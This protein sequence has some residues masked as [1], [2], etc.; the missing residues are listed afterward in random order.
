M[1]LQ[2]S[3]REMSAKTRRQGR[4]SALA[5]QFVAILLIG[6]MAMPT[7][8]P[9]QTLA[10]DSGNE[11]FRV[12]LKSREFVPVPGV[13]PAMKRQQQAA[14]LG[15]RIHVLVQ[16]WQIPSGA[17]RATLENAA[18]ELLAYV[19]ANTW[20]ASMPA[21]L[22]LQSDA[23]AGVRWIGA[24][25]P[26][27]RMAPTLRAGVIGPHATHDDGT[28]SLDV[29]FLADVTNVEVTRL[30]ARYNGEIEAK[31]TDFHR[32][33]VRLDPRAIS[34]LAGEDGV[35]WIAE[36]A[37][38][39]TT[40]NDGARARTNADA[41]QSAPYNL[42]GSGVDLGIW[43]GGR[44]D[45][46]VDFSGRLTVVDAGASVSDHAT[47]VAGTMAGDGSNSAS[48][49][50]SPLQW[51]GMAPGADIISYYWD[52]NLIDHNG[53]INTYGIELSQNSWGYT[54]KQ[55]WPYQNCYLYGN[56]DYDAPDYDDIITGRYGK[57]I[58]V[59]FSAGNERN[60]GDCG[61]SGTPPY[62]N[63]ANIGPPATAKNIIAV[64]A[65]NSNDDSMTS[66]SSWGPMDDGRI[67][68]D[69]VAPGCESTGEGYIHSTLPGNIYGGPD[70]CGTSMAAPVVSGISAL[71]IQQ[72]H[73]TFGADPLPS[74]LK[75]LLVQTAV[76]MDDGTSYYNPGPD[77]ASG[78]GRVDAQAAVAEVIAQH[79]REDHVSHGQTDSFTVNVPAGTP[80]LKVTLAW[81]DEPGAVNAN[82]AL[83]NNL[84]LILVEPNGTTTHLPWLLDPANPSNDATTGTDSVNNVEQVQVNNPVAGTWQVQVAGTSVPMGPQDYSL[85]GQTFTPG[86]G[87]T[88]PTISG[89]P[90][91]TLPVN[92]SRDNAIDLWAY[93][94][95]TEDSDSDLTFTISNSPD[96]NAGVS[97]DSSNRYIDINPTTDWTG[98]TDV[99]VQ[100]EDTGNLTDTDSFQV[101]VITL[102]PDIGVSPTSFEETVYEGEMVTKTLTIS[103]TG[104]SDLDFSIQEQEGITTIVLRLWKLTVPQSDTDIPTDKGKA[105]VAALST[106]ENTG[107]TPEPIAP[108]LTAEQLESL[109]KLFSTQPLEGKELG[110]LD[111][112]LA[113][114]EL[115]IDDGT[116]ENGLVLS[117]PLTMIEFRVVL[118]NHF[119][120]AMLAGFP[121]TLDRIDIHEDTH[122][123]QGEQIQLLVYA[124]AD[125]GDPSNATLLYS[126]IVNVQTQNGWNSY[127]LAN[128]VVVSDPA[129]ILI[130]FSTYYADGGVP[131]PGDRFPYP[132]DE[133]APQGRSYLASMNDTGDS[134]DPSDLSSF[135]NLVEMGDTS[136]PANW[137]IRGYGSLGGDVPWLSEEPISGTVPAGGSLPMDVIFNATGLA[138]GDYTASLVISSND[139]DENPVTV[140]VVLHVLAGG[141]GTTNYLPIIL[142]N[143]SDSGRPP[144]P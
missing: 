46:H 3:S 109:S 96:T 26:E 90:D 78:Y 130:G 105:T 140:P 87:N 9:Y 64:G 49:G 113:D 121:F 97:I 72:Y 120:A 102:V 25:Q 48:Q 100:V 66:F 68:P 44:V 67:K 54:I 2:E 51:R 81:D 12:R 79:I 126:E 60:D 104:D 10:Q 133:T 45:T 69:V 110:K 89:L 131:W 11:N 23:L 106:V 142:K 62:I 1:S 40:D 30:L 5:R 132:M 114:V 135:P 52:N 19:P 75:A 103:N 116:Q 129:D 6:L 127:T 77:Y 117:H 141:A 74:T 37:P 13:E 32:F 65:T 20:F 28:V 55:A 21:G 118:F 17:E 31:A 29:R 39:K 99:E 33:T 59:I 56:Y 95:D 38:P 112:P 111:A 84:D 93:A 124:D 125:G 83:V 22:S 14:S 98:T 134:V 86:G 57:R 34:S 128:P 85:A 7:L 115:I 80:S 35:Q 15:E 53:A 63:Y 16:F 144:P 107:Y 18:V 92:T 47:H 101:A 61:M 136:A 58:S 50:G 122:N 88:P 27:D 139:P 119:D 43:D 36:A 73:T 138:Q 70:W 108:K 91:Q 82:P 137:L 123:L 76:D 4:I 41:V 94:S 42:S 24:I 143:Y 8:V 71:L